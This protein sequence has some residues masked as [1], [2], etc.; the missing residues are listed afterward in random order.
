MTWAFG[1]LNSIVVYVPSENEHKLTAGFD[2]TWVKSSL[3]GPILSCLYGY[4][5]LHV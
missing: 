5:Q 1:A 4:S 3:Y 2:Q